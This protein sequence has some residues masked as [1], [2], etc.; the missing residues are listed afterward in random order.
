MAF[1][2]LIRRIRIGMTAAGPVVTTVLRL[3]GARLPSARRRR[4]VLLAMAAVIVIAAFFVIVQTPMI[5]ANTATAAMFGAFD[6]TDPQ[7]Q[8]PPADFCAPVPS[9]PP[10]PE[11]PP[12]EQA[13]PA[14]AQLDPLDADGRPTSQTLEIIAQ[15]PA[16]AELDTATA[17]ILFRLAHPYEADHADYRVFNDAYTAT[18][19]AMSANAAPLDV[20]ATMDPTADYSPF[21][22][23]AQAATYRLVRQGSVTASDAQIHALIAALGATCAG[24]DRRLSTP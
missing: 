1:S 4:W 21:L 7:Q 12:G 20:V 10:P 11:A 14:S 23:I 16:G 8:G 17:W 19:S 13:N 9:V 2:P 18:R 24:P 3:T 5:I 15:V 22:L 6:S